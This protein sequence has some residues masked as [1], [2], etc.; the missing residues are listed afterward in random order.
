MVN[1]IRSEQQ[2]FDM[3][4]NFVRADIVTVPGAQV[5]WPYGGKQRQIVVDLDPDRLHAWKRDG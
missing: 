2:L 4:V 5:P 1:E 3:G